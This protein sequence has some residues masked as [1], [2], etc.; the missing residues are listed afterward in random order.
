MRVLLFSEHER[1]YYNW[2]RGS[3]GVKGIISEIYVQLTV[4][5]IVVETSCFNLILISVD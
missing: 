2:G 1:K 3:V 4:V 5:A